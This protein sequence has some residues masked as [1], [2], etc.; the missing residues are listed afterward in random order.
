[1]VID[2]SVVLKWY[3]LDEVLGDKALAL[4]QRHY[5]G[6]LQLIAPSLLTYELANGL[7][8]ASRRGRVN[9]ETV[10]EALNGFVALDITLIDSRRF[11]ARLP[12]FSQDFSLSAYDA[13]YAA[14]AELENA[15]L[16]T[17]DERLYRALASVTDLALWLGDS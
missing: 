12:T 4:L 5:Q 16:V 2:A 1:M 17:A 13:A 7:V 3:L 11:Y 9:S 10:I 6:H 15:P 14:V 8:V